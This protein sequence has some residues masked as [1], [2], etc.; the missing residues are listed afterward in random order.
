[1]RDAVA[2]VVDDSDRVLVKWPNDVVIRERTGSGYR[3]VAGILVEAAFAGTKVEHIVIGVGVNVLTRDFPSDLTNIATSVALESSREPHRGE[4]LASIL[5]S[6]DHDVEHVAHRG[7]GIVHARLSAHD[8][9]S[10]RDVES[11]DGS[12]RGVACGIDPDGR[13]MVRQADGVIAK[14]SSGEM[15]VRVAS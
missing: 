11:E 6:L 5:A 8:A 2:S 9:L 15:R 1:V 3:K 10:G 13:L 4:I 14:V 12:I 7:L